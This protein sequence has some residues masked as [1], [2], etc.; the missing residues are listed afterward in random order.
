MQPLTRHCPDDALPTLDTCVPQTQAARGFRHAPAVHAGVPGPRRHTVAA[1]LPGPSAALRTGGPRFARP[2][3]P[4]RVER[5]RPGRPP[6]RTGALAPPRPRLLAHTPSRTAP[7]MPRGVG[8]H[9]PRA[10]PSSQ[11]CGSA[12]SACAACEKT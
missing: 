5:P 9:V 1:A 3:T 10:S 6:H 4:G 2:G 7:S 11:G 8:R 12:V